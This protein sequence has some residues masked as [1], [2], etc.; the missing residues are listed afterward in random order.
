MVKL[1]YLYITDTFS[2]TSKTV[3][4]CETLHCE[5]PHGE[6]PHGEML[7][8]EMLHSEMLHSEMPLVCRWFV[9]ARWELYSFLCAL[10][11]ERLSNR[12]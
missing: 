11:V 7:H 4:H 10:N 9:M 1:I 3:L 8:S 2:T 5:M 12:S 6:M